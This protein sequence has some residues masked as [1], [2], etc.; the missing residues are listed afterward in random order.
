[1]E[2]SGNYQGALFANFSGNDTPM[3]ELSLA[4]Y[5]YSHQLINQLLRKQI[6]F[7]NC[8]LIQLAYNQQQIKQQQQILQTGFAKDLCYQ[9]NKEQLQQI[10]GIPINCDSGLFYPH[11]LWVDP[12]SL[13]KALST[14]PNIT[15]KLNSEI[16]ELTQLSKFN[17]QIKDTAGNIDYAPNVVLCNSY[18]IN[19]F[20]QLSQ[21]YLRIIRGQMSMIPQLNNLKTIICANGYITPNKGNSYVIGATFKF[22]DLDNQIKIAEHLENINNFK[23]IMPQITNA[24][25]TTNIQGKVS[26]RS[27]TTDYMPLLGPIANY[28]KFKIAYQDLAKDSNYWIETPCPYLTGLFVNAAHGAK[29]ILTAPI[30][31]E[32]IADYIDN[33]QFSISEKLRFALHPNRFWRKEIITGGIAK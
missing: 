14:N 16:C 4:G 13:V 15:I 5:N 18:A 26:F 33:T 27:S 32:I 29:G 6:D 20:T 1:M 31:G 22:K 21:I 17:W 23:D 9:L 12:R 7:D 24:I 28:D 11:G 25:D 10:S 8:G 19:K 3:L 30:C 2:A